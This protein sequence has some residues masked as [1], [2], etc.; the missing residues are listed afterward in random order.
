MEQTVGL[1]REFWYQFSDDKPDLIK[2]Y[3]IGAKLFPLKLMV[4]RNWKKIEKYNGD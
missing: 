1:L 4:E 2:L 3:D